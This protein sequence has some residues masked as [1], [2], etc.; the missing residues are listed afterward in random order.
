M[1]P[2]I[3]AVIYVVGMALLLFLTWNWLASL[4]VGV[5]R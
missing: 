1:R 3:G 4:P 2:L 5:P